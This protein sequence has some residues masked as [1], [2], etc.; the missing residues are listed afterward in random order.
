MPK[1]IPST[2]NYKKMSSNP[3]MSSKKERKPKDRNPLTFVLIFVGVWIISNILYPEPFNALYKAMDFYFL[4][5]G[6]TGVQLLQQGEN[7]LAAYVIVVQIAAWLAFAFFVK[8]TFVDTFFPKFRIV[9]QNKDFYTI[10]RKIK[11]T[12]GKDP[13]YMYFRV[14]FYFRP[15]F[16]WHTLKIPKPSEIS[17]GI[18]FINRK[19][20]HVKGGFRDVK[21]F[22][23]PAHWDIHTNTLHLN[24][25][26]EESCYELGLRANNFR[27]DPAAPY[28]QLAFDGVQNVGT[29]IIE[30]VKGDFGLIKGQFNMGIVIRERKLPEENPLEDKEWKKKTSER[31]S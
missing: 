8:V 3:E 18:P 12:E 31:D 14:K 11:Q 24:F 27:P 2:K 13:R 20:K 29:Q 23:M 30:S 22:R 15:I 6:Y 26:P 9:T 1:I 7:G 21:W 16:S 17:Q 5:F 10:A 25:N 28:N 4:A 19:T